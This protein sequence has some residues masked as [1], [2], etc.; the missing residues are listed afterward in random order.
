MICPSDDSLLRAELGELEHHLT[1]ELREHEALCPRCRALLHEQRRLILDLAAPPAFSQS[2]PEF[3][4]AVLGRCESAD[5]RASV[6]PKARSRAPLYAALVLAAGVGFWI[7]RPA[8]LVE[9]IAARGGI[10]SALA[11]TRI[12]ARL[13]RDGALLPLDGARLHA[14]DGITARYVKRNAR[15][16][17]L[18]LFAID[19]SGA[20]HWIFPAYL[21][22]A[23]DPR[24]ILLSAQHAGRLLED[25]VEPESPA[26]GRLRVVAVVSEEPHGV[27]EIERRLASGEP[28]SALFAG[29]HVQ[30]WSST[31]IA[32]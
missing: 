17:Y 21:D 7:L 3:L 22:P 6:G 32:R 15:P 1:L 20:V 4:A 8:A 2:E 26:P 12:E 14:G 5:E 30:E 23:T 27:K 19:A 13:V 25:T 31:W 11:E 10:H 28:L 9:H 24:S 16:E 29:D 18:A